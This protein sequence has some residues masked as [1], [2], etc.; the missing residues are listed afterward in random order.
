VNLTGA[1]LTPVINYTP[2]AGDTL[3]LITDPAGSISGTFAGLADGATITLNGEPWRVNYGTHAVTLTAGPLPQTIT[4]TSRPPSPA[5]YGG[6]YTPAATGGASGN[7]VTFSTDPASAGCTLSGGTVLFTAA[8]TCIIDA[9]QAG[10]SN[11]LSAAAQQ[12]FSITAAPLVIT[13]SSASMTYGGAVPAIT[14]Q[15]AGFVNGDS[16]GSLTATPVCGTTATPASPA[17]SYP[18][19]C[20]GAADP[21]YLISY[22][23]G[24]VSVSPA[25]TTTA[26]TGP[27]QVPVN[28]TIAPGA[29]LASTAAACQAGQQ[30]TFSLDTNPLTGAPGAYTLESATTSSTGAATGAAVSTT[31]WRNGVYTMTAAFA[32][33]PNCTS[34]S[35]TGALAVTAPGEAAIGAGSYTVPNAGPVSFGFIVATAHTTSGYAGQLD[36]VNQG[37]WWLQANLS[38]YGKTGSNQGIINGTGNLYWWN[39]A[40]NHGRGGWQLAKTGVPCTAAFTGTSKTSPGSFG[41]QISYTPAGPQPPVLPNSN[42]I[43]LTKGKIAL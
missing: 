28:A 13:A 39:P 22:S 7:P 24:T 37:R 29:T 19:T 10:N 3:T 23:N 36:L 12:S 41:I 18:A 14:P 38:S 30:I 27:T 5:V 6:S 31:G 25:G 9:S 2:S 42:P 17:G 34:S 32:G 43:P 16:P 20:H 11:Y 1:T 4:F 35:G 8:G 40:L 26:Y 33:T 15:Y 21:N